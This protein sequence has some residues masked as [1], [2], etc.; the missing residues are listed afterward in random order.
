MA[1]PGPELRQEL[2]V[3]SKAYTSRLP[4]RLQEIEKAFRRWRES[5]L[6]REALDELRSLSHRLTG[7]AATYG[8]SEVSETAKTLE[9]LLRSAGS[10]PSDDALARLA[11]QISELR[12]EVERAALPAGKSVA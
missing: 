10:P 5:P 7:S 3:L 1:T 8:V 6:E 9:S 4:E 12:L 11:N 2:L